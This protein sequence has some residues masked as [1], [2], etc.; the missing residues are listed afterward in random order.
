MPPLVN[1]NKVPNIR[2]NC[3]VNVTNLS[4]TL[5]RPSPNTEVLTFFPSI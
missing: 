2:D 5:G 1:I 3:I 4:P